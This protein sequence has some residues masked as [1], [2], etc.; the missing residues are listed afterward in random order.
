M[1][2]EKICRFFKNVFFVIFLTLFPPNRRFNHDFLVFPKAIFKCTYE[3][4]FLCLSGF[5]KVSPS[6]IQS[7][8]CLKR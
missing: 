1:E 7:Y 8:I 3:R 6:V 5:E 2:V 4:N